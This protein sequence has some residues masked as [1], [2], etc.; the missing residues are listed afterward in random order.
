MDLLADTHLHLYP[1]FDCDQVFSTCINRLSGEF[2]AAF[3]AERAD[4][5]FY[6]QL[7]QGNRLLSQF[8]IEQTDVEQLVL[9]RMSDGHS[10]TLVPGRQIITAEGIEVLALGTRTQFL[11]GQPAKAII[12]AIQSSEGIPVLP[13]SPG[14]WLFHRGQVVDRLLHHFSN[15]DFLI[16][17]VS[18]RPQGWGTPLLIRKAKSL[19]YKVICGSD[20]LPFP[21]EEQSAGMYASRIVLPETPASAAAALR[22]VLL[23]EAQVF[24]WGKRSNPLEALRRLHQ[25]AQVRKQAKLNRIK[26]MI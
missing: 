20:P 25:N 11:D 6:A 9:C 17:D 12:S 4:C 19:G 24:S 15:Q 14:K 22:A 23:G 18:L 2:R 3:L 26:E 21:G 8:T 1:C 5:T 16:G 7:C 13:W 10:L